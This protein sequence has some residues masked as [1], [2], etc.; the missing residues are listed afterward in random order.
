MDRQ[1]SYRFVTDDAPPQREVLCHHSGWQR[2][3]WGACPA[4]LEDVAGPNWEGQVGGVKIVTTGARVPPSVASSWIASQDRPEVVRTAARFDGGATHYRLAR[5]NRTW[6]ARLATLGVCGL[7][8]WPCT[9]EIR[10]KR[11]SSCPE[12]DVSPPALPS[13]II[14]HL[15][16]FAQP[17]NAPTID[18]VAKLDRP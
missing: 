1:R 18:V 12:S 17:A 6:C 9:S 4:T 2:R 11:C 15:S 14:R 7:S 16:H 8:G 10:L 5:Q 3:T 13:N